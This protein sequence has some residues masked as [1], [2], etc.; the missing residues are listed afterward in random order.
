[1]TDSYNGTP[2][3]ESESGEHADAHSGRGEPFSDSSV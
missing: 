1:M 3:E 2:G